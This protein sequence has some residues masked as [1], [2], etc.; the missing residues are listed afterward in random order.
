MTAPCGWSGA[1]KAD[2]KGAVAAAIGAAV[3]NLIPVGG[4]ISYGDAMVTG[5]VGN[6]AHVRHE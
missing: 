2:L 1:A 4:Q 3:W 6:S 5:G